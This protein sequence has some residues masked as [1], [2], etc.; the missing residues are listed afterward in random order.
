MSIGGHE[1]KTIKTPF[2]LLLT[3]KFALC[4]EAS[5]LYPSMTSPIVEDKRSPKNAEYRKNR[6]SDIK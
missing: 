1:S 2:R 4:T 6:Y 5:P 3:S